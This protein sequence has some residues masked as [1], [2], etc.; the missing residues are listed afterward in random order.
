MLHLIT[1]D[2]NNNIPT[3]PHAMTL[4]MGYKK[5]LQSLVLVH[6]SPLIPLAFMLDSELISLS[7]IEE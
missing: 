3:I 4:Q 1:L 5:S 7:D 6:E 2:N